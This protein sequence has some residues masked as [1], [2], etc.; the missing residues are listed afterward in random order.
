MREIQTP[1]CFP[2][3]GSTNYCPK[4]SNE[5]SWQKSRERH[6]QAK[7]ET[8]PSAIGTGGARCSLQA[9][10]REGQLALPEL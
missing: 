2:C 3:V 5:S 10:P 9:G 7:A 8:T 4:N 1:W 6:V